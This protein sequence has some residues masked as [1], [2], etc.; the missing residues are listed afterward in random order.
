VA[1]S[2]WMMSCGIR[3]LAGIRGPLRALQGRLGVVR[4]GV[5]NSFGGSG[6]IG[7]DG[8]LA[9]A[10]SGGF[11]GFSTGAKS[12]DGLVSDDN[13]GPGKTHFG[14]KDVDV[15]EKEELV[16]EVFHSVAEQYDVMND[17][18]S[19]TLHRVWKDEFVN[20]LL[21]VSCAGYGGK[22]IDV[23]GGTGD[24]AFR[25]V[26]RSNTMSPRDPPV[27]VTVCDI[28]ASMLKVGEK[29]AEKFGLDKGQLSFVEVN[30][31]KLKQFEDNTFDAYTIAFG[32]RNV[33]HIENAL[34]EA[35][36]VLKP[37]GR[38]MCL[39]FSHVANPVIQAIYEK[40]SFHVIPTVGQLV[41]N[42]RDAYQ[43]LVE[44]IRKFPKQ[45]EF[46]R[47]IREAGFSHVT[48]TN[49]TCGVVAIHSGFKL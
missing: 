29:R 38:F 26:E 9:G 44:S 4:P 24:I 19:G 46:E 2:K 17:L 16:K 39:E 21:P 5:C 40:Y 47:M 43:Y 22:V 12:G 45:R 41:A 32:I 18:M 15:E 10:S 27:G 25:I 34:S 23:A 11:R 7:G 35:Y 20:M 14:F 1:L 37:G 49:L 13:D 8:W 6:R 31:E 33:T 28:N 48:H 42:D 3:S 30:A 36:R